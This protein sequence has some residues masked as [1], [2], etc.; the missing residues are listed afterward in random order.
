M[1]PATIRKLCQLSD[2]DLYPTRR[3]RG[4]LVWRDQGHD[5]WCDGRRERS[6]Q[7]L[8]RGEAPERAVLLPAAR[9]ALLVD[10]GRG[11][12]SAVA[13]AAFDH[14][15]DRE[16]AHSDAGAGA[17]VVGSFRRFRGAVLLLVLDSGS[18]ILV[19]PPEGVAGE[20]TTA[21]LWAEV[22]LWRAVYDAHRPDPA[23][24]AALAA[25]APCELV[26][27]MATWCHLSKEHV[28]R[29]L[30]ALDAAANPSIRLRLVSVDHGFEEPPVIHQ[31]GIT[32]VP[33]CIV[34][35][36]GAELGRV[37]ETPADGSLAADVAGILGGTPTAHNGRWARRAELARGRYRFDGGAS[38]E[39]RLFS[40]D[41]EGLLLHSRILRPGGRT[42]L[43][44][45]LDRHGRPDL[46][47]QTEH[48]GESRSRLR[49]LVA[50]DRLTVVVRGTRCGLVEQSLRIGAGFAFAA[51]GAAAAAGWRGLGAA[52][53]VYLLPG[54][55]AWGAGFLMPAC[56]RQLGRERC[57]LGGG[58]AD[59]LRLSVEVGGDGACGG[60]GWREE[61]Q[62]LEGLGLPVAG[63][64]EAAAL[65]Q[66]EMADARVVEEVR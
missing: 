42:E 19:V 35:R 33:T 36:G 14:A 53:D 25:A 65:E 27:T 61:W 13:A 43:W 10:L 49:A 38:E 46:L 20:L 5:V 31:L 34:R 57:A 4:T 44:L 29:L 39:F 17:R 59:T 45:R 9:E 47:E 6:A 50:D 56:S 41:G 18:Q 12:V 28:P 32:N 15:P 24:T 37:V 3:E 55:R 58:V 66:L 7:V 48:E 8:V 26:V 62:L 64:T 54:R 52:G 60:G 21:D 51:A 30:R 16:S 40:T 11:L 1:N 23:A 22:P 2:M 63:G